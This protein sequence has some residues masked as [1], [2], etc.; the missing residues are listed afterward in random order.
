[1]LGR[2]RSGSTRRSRAIDQPV[3]PAIDFQSGCPAHQ[4]WQRTRRPLAQYPVPVGLERDFA[5]PQR[6]AE[7][8]VQ[9]TAHA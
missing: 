1:M 7:M 6:A 8:L 5:D 3:F 4:L 9:L 2:R